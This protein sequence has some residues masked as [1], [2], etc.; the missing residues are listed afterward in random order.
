[1]KQSKHTPGPWTSDGL[2]I[3]QAV[4]GRRISMLKIGNAVHRESDARLIAAAP[5]LLEA[6]QK[7]MHAIFKYAPECAARLNSADELARLQDAIIKATGG[8]K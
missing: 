4:N 6:A 1:M 3:W 5:E 8:A 2:E 7:L